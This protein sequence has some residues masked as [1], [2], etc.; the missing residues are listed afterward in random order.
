MADE[1][2]GPATPAGG[3]TGPRRWRAAGSSFL[4]DL[5][6]LSQANR[7]QISDV[8]NSERVRKVLDSDLMRKY[9]NLPGN[10]ATARFFRENERGKWIADSGRKFWEKHYVRP[11]GPQERYPATAAKVVGVAAAVG[12]LGYAV[13]RLRNIRGQEDPRAGLEREQAYAEQVRQEGGILLTDP[14]GEQFVVTDQ[15]LADVRAQR[16]RAQ[17]ADPRFAAAATR[18]SGQRVGMT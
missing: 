9:R 15:D 10:Q 12:A 14:D 4:R 16:A 3:S 8:V 1:T 17:A 18:P 13:H 5:R 11:H 6:R 2:A 7:H